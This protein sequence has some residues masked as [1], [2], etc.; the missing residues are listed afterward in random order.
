VLIQPEF[1]YGAGRNSQKPNPA[2]RITYMLMD[3]KIQHNLH[4]VVHKSIL[5]L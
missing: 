1:N 2:I 5:I 4:Y 3:K